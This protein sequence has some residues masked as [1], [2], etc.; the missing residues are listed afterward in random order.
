MNDQEKQKL[1]NIVAEGRQ[2]IHFVNQE[3][4][5]QDF[6]RNAE[7]IGKIL[8]MELEEHERNWWWQIGGVVKGQLP[9]FVENVLSKYI[10][11]YM[12][13]ILFFK[14]MRW[15]DIASVEAFSECRQ[16]LSE[17]LTRTNPSLV[18]VLS[19]IEKQL[20]IVEDILKKP[21]KLEIPKSDSLERWSK[22]YEKRTIGFIAFLMFC[23]IFDFVLVPYV[24]IEIF[25]TVVG[26]QIAI[27]VFLPSLWNWLKHGKS[28]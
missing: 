27:I 1:S 19:I 23:I 15:D 17:E 7:T 8:S 16:Q 9:N 22:G 18:I 24:T 2:L 21:P 10:S 25:L 26:A 6:M 20:S 11:W 13:C 28:T 14:A 5:N 12:D 3:K 4:A